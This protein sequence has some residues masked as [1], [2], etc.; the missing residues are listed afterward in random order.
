[1][2]RSMPPWILGLRGQPIPPPED[3]LDTP[4]LIEA[5]RDLTER[6]RAVLYLRTVL[7]LSQVETAVVLGVET[8][9]YGDKTQGRQVLVS[10]AEVSARKKLKTL[11]SRSTVG[12]SKT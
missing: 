1:M 11:L 6:E 3:W 10:R 8:P 7:R 12:T 2:S 4:E 5:V 9:Q